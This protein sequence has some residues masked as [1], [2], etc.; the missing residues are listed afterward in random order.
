[1]ATHTHVTLVQQD[2]VWSTRLDRPN[3]EDYI[4]MLLPDGIVYCNITIDDSDSS[5]DF[6]D[7]TPTVPLHHPQ[8]V[9]Y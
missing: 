4:L 1:M 7:G 5:R 9:H 2:G 8:Q 6:D 3:D